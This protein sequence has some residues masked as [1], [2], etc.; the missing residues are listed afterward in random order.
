[1]RTSGTWEKPQ[2]SSS[3]SR[4]LLMRSRKLP[5]GVCASM[6]LPG[7]RLRLAELVTWRRLLKTTKVCSS[8]CRSSGTCHGP[9]DL[10]LSHP[11]FRWARAM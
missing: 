7:A 6:E 3:S 4:A 5:S 2:R 8:L 9:Q 10:M 11:N 1:M